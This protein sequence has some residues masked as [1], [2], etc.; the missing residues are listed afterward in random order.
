VL[1]DADREDTLG[2][3]TQARL[4]EIRS[5]LGQK[6]GLSRT[7]TRSYA[8]APVSLA[9]RLPRAILQVSDTLW[10]PLVRLDQAHP[11]KRLFT[12]RTSA[13]SS[14]GPSVASSA[15]PRRLNASMCASGLLLLR[16]R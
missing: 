12:Y 13:S 14:L 5:F 6:L 4:K 9:Q 2:R 10:D 15:I 7:C 11:S 3:R 16:N 8:N 1:L